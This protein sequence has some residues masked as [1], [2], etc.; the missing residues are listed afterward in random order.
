MQIIDKTYSTLST[1]NIQQTLDLAQI[2]REKIADY[3]QN[4]CLSDK[5]IQKCML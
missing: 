3:I 5:Y 1:I 2:G 4:F